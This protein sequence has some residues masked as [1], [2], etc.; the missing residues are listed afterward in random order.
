MISKMFQ[1]TISKEKRL[2]ILGKDVWKYVISIIENVKKN[3]KLKTVV[4]LKL[5]I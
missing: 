5:L 3:L 2:W 4:F 1:T